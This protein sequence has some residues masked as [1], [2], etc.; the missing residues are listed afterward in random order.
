MSLIFPDLQKDIIFLKNV[1]SLSENHMLSPL[2]DH[3]A[4]K[5][6]RFLLQEGFC[7]LHPI[8]ATVLVHGGSTLN[9]HGQISV[10]Y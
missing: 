9:C 7:Y 6:L 2:L 10:W 4:P 3:I 8:T 1:E 5:T